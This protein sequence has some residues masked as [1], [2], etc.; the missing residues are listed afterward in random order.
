MDSKLLKFRQLLK[1]IQSYSILY[2]NVKWFIWIIFDQIFTKYF[3]E[4]VQK[5]VQLCLN[6]FRILTLEYFSKQ[7]ELWN[8]WEWRWLSENNFQIMS[9]AIFELLAMFDS[10]NVSQMNIKWQMEDDRCELVNVEHYTGKIKLFWYLHQLNELVEIIQ[11]KISQQLRGLLRKS[12][13]KFGQRLDISTGTLQRIQT[14]DS[15]IHSHKI[16]CLKIF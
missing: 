15:Q 11:N 8:K 7:N 9:S 14:E 16:L 1:K 12:C 4:S 10:D 5:C 2:L 3:V 13:G 6:K